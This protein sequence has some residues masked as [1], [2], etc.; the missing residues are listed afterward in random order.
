MRWWILGGVVL[1]SACGSEGTSTARPEPAVAEAVSEVEPAE[2][3]DGEG[4]VAAPDRAALLAELRAQLDELADLVD[5]DEPVR[6][7]TNQDVGPLV[8][9][10]GDELQAALGAPQHCA[11]TR[12]TWFYSF[13]RLPPHWRGG[14]PSLFLTLDAD[15]VCT[16]ARWQHSR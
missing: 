8:G 14:G 13:F 3:E 2:V 16:A 6:R 1:L 10:T 9:L 15:G 7:W 5:F 4:A 11:D 12:C